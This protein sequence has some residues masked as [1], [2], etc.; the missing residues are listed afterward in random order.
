MV[1]VFVFEN[2]LNEVQTALI[3]PNFVRPPSPVNGIRKKY[4]YF[5]QAH[6]LSGVTVTQ[7]NSYFGTLLASILAKLIEL[8][9]TYERCILA[10]PKKLS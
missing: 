9:A 5:S 3:R 1:Q 10:H 8:K 6:L 7:P 2:I 4:H